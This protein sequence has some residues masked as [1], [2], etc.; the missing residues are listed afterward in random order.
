MEVVLPL[1]I[2]YLCILTILLKD[3]P[4]NLTYKGN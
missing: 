1:T 3:R 4:E 2:P